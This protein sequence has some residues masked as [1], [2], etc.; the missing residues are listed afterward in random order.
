MQNIFGENS[1]GKVYN[2]FFGMQVVY[3]KPSRI[4]SSNGEYTWTIWEDIV[5]QFT[6]ED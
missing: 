3:A 1:E 4:L 6:H 2:L 5:A